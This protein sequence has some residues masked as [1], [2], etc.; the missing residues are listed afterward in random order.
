MK[1]KDSTDMIENAIA[2]VEKSLLVH[3]GLKNVKTFLDK[4]DKSYL[5][6]EDKIDVLLEVKIDFAVQVGMALDKM[7]V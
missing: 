1:V 6:R 5:S 3:E 4:V 7:Y 2:N